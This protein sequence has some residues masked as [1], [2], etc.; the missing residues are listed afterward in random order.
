LNGVLPFWEELITGLLNKGE[1]ADWGT[2]WRSCTD[3]I[4]TSLFQSNLDLGK[5]FDESLVTKDIYI[6]KV[7]IL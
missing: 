3:D 4:Q 1:K 5:S 2:L 6:S 7:C